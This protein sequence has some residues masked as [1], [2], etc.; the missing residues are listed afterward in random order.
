MSNSSS[1][2]LSNPLYDQLKR[3]TTVLLPGVGALYFALAQIWGL[4]AAEEV[5]GTIAAVNVFLGLV[6]NVSS[7]S[8]DNSDQ[9]FD[10]VAHLSNQDG[11][12]YIGLEMHEGPEAIA[13]KKEVILKVEDRTV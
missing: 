8:Y 3:A 11:R 6:V 1:I 13:D 5:V 10:G 12:A 9:K 2:Q 7:K 4:P